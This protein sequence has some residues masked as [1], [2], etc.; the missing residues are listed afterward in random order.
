MSDD[1]PDVDRSL[2]VPDATGAEDKLLLETALV[3]TAHVGKENS[4]TSGE[5]SEALGGIDTLDSTPNTRAAIRELVCEYNMPIG[6]YHGGYYL[7]SDGDEAQSCIET[8]STRAA[9]IHRRMSA[10]NKAMADHGYVTDTTEAD[11]VFEDIQRAILDDVE[12]GP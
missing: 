4:I 3:L 2:D 8:L 11:E 1:H 5:L 12:S 7:L 9:G 10:L 6:S